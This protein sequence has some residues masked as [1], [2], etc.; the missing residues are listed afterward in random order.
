VGSSPLLAKA[1]GSYI[2]AITPGVVV[3]SAIVFHAMKIPYSEMYLVI[4]LSA[5]YGKSAWHDYQQSR[6]I[7]EQAPKANK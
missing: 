5:S 3:I 2:H 7:N 1:I 6:S 4:L